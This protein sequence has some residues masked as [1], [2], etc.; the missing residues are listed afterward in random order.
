MEPKKEKKKNSPRTNC[1]ESL[2]EKRRT[3]L[4]EKLQKAENGSLQSIQLTKEE[5]SEV[6]NRKKYGFNLKIAVKGINGKA[7][8]R[9]LAIVLIRSGKGSKL[10]QKGN[11]TMKMDKNFL[12][13][14]TKL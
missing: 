4:I 9:G 13:T 14:I 2:W 10:L 11:Y 5:F 3:E 8:A 6:V 7:Q 1:C 12:L